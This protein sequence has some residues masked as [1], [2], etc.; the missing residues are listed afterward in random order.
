LRLGRIYLVFVRLEQAIDALRSPL[1]MA[2][3]VNPISRHRDHFWLLL[4]QSPLVCR[5]ILRD[6]SFFAVWQARC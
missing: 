5:G 6:I 3:K 1:L 2:L 4:I